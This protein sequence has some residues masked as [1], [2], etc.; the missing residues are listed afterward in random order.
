MADCIQVTQN[1]S[2]ALRRRH[3]GAATTTDTVTDEKSRMTTAPI[4]LRV[5]ASARQQG[6]TSR[7]IA[8]AFE[9]AWLARH[10]S[11]QVRRRDLAVQALPHISARTIEGFYTAAEQLDVGL[12]EATALSD[13]LISELKAAHTLL[14]A[15]PIYNF[16]MPSAL[17]AWIDQI[18]RIGHTFAFDGQQFTGLVTQPRAVL[19]LAYGAGGYQGPLMAMDHLKPYLT[20]L[21]GFLGIRCVDV[22]SAEGTTTDPA[23]AQAALASAKAQIP[24]LI[25]AAG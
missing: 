9:Q 20:Q 6:S 25:A 24:D 18:V 13:A 22:L 2:L 14:I 12:R 3:W 10:P 11:G 1:P 7:A 16:S 17:K 5:D 23:A 21:L 8:D 15:A 4:L 19:A